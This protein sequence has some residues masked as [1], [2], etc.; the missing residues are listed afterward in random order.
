MV[1]HVKKTFVRIPHLPRSSFGIPPQ[2]PIGHWNQGYRRV[3]E[4]I[5]GTISRSTHSVRY[6]D[7]EQYDINQQQTDL[8][9]VLLD[10]I[11]PAAN[12]TLVKDLFN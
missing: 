1:S 12:A 11:I 7:T 3:E 9:H 6:F 10:I 2:D 4:D 8:A 5:Q